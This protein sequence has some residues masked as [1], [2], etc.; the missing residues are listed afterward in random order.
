MTF[1]VDPR[2]MTDKGVSLAAEQRQELM[3]PPQPRPSIHL[4][5]CPPENPCGVSEPGFKTTRP[6]QLTFKDWQLQ[7]GRLRGEG[8]PVKGPGHIQRFGVSGMEE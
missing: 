2:Y 6:L 5:L 4:S 7:D 8:R 3:T 1:Y